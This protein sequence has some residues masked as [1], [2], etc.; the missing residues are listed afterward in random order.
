MGK[1][2][3]FYSTR[4]GYLSYSGIIEGEPPDEE[5]YWGEAEEFAVAA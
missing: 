4:S 5:L 1:I 3:I 2:L